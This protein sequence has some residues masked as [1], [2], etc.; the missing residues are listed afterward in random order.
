MK[1]LSIDS[2]LG[3]LGLVEEEDHICELIFGAET[4]THSSALL[5]EAARQLCA[6][7]DRKLKQFDLPLA[8]K[9]TVFQKNVCLEMLKIP[10]GEVVTYGALAARLNSSAR[11][12]GGA[13]GHNPIAILIPCHRVVG[14]AGKLTGYSGAG[15]LATKQFLL[16][17]ETH[18]QSSF[19]F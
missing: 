5:E 2:P 10:Y 7:F 4:S 17:H 12:V 15:G 11:A 8:P 13:C 9:G 6:Y 3:P 19:A 18:Q 16:N 1:L 14:A